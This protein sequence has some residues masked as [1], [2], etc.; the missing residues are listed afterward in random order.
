[1]V[2]FSVWDLHHIL[3]TSQYETFFFKKNAISNPIFIGMETATRSPCSLLA[4]RM[5]RLEWHLCHQGSPWALISNS[6]TPLLSSECQT[7]RQVWY[8][9]TFWQTRKPWVFKILLSSTQHLMK[10]VLARWNF[11]LRNQWFLGICQFCGWKRQDT[12][13]TYWGWR[14]S[15]E[16]TL[17][18]VE[19]WKHFNWVTGESQQQA[20][21]Y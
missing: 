16:T 14:R 8:L 1:M 10:Y 5:W 17:W 4:W 7:N 6:T 20:E 9:A 19:C 11:F 15:K 21:C 2:G 13:G 12:K 18:S 3:K